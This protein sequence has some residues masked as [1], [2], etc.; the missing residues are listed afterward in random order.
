MYLIGICSQSPEQILFWPTFPEIWNIRGGVAIEAT[1]RATS[2][3]IKAKFL[4]TGTH[5]AF[6]G[7]KRRQYHFFKWLMGFSA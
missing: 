6:P 1:I 3:R 2:I 5:R 7:I 4:R